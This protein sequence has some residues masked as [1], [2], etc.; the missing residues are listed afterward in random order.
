MQD[1]WLQAS[2]AFRTGARRKAKRHITSAL[3]RT[4]RTNSLQL[5]IHE[6]NLQALQTQATTQSVNRTTPLSTSPPFVPTPHSAPLAL[7]AEEASLIAA[8]NATLHSLHVALSASSSS[9][10]IPPA[11]TLPLEAATPRLQSIAIFLRE[12][13]GPHITPP[14]PSSAHGTHGFSWKATRAAFDALHGVILPLVKAHPDLRNVIRRWMRA[15]TAALDLLSTAYIYMSRPQD[16]IHVADVCRGVH[17][18]AAMLYDGCD[19]RDEDEDGDVGMHDEQ[20]DEEARTEWLMGIATG[21]H[22]GVDSCLQEIV[23]RLPDTDESSGIGLHLPTLYLAGSLLM[24]RGTKEDV[25]MGRGVL[26]ICAARGY[27]VA[28][29]LG[30]I[31]RG[32]CGEEAAEMWKRALAVESNEAGANLWCAAMALMRLGRNEGAVKILECLQELERG[33]ACDD[34]ARDRRKVLMGAEEVLWKGGEGKVTAAIGRALCGAGRWKEAANV[35][36]E[37]VDGGT[38]VTMDKAWAIVCSGEAKT[39]IEVAEVGYMAAGSGVEKAG[40]LLAKVEGLVRLGRFGDCGAEIMRSLKVARLAESGAEDWEGANKA[41]SILR[42]VCFYN[43]GVLGAE[44]RG[45]GFLMADE[46]LAAAQTA[47]AKGGDGD[48]VFKHVADRWR[49][50]TGFAR[51]VVMWRGGRARDAAGHWLAL[52]GLQEEDEVQGNEE[53]SG[54]ECMVSVEDEGGVVCD[55]GDEWFDMLD[56]VALRYLRVCD[57]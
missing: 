1:D 47:F 15:A 23:G 16:A 53:L 50:V 35:L 54:V 28:E 37:N 21:L 27:R 32:A 56:V 6:I 3:R 33:E 30:L 22:S 13:E 24:Q 39:G 46:C 9:S 18:V 51:C 11:V 2:T 8:H 14:A 25:S 40:C 41:S 43:L 17:Y 45:G 38:E 52:R 42:G 29:C 26:E 10:A 57:L 20:K 55:V 36:R 12:Y 48:G 5:A 4:S 44:E 31:A 49:V 19:E 34:D 7:L